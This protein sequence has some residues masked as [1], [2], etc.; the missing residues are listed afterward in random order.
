[1]KNINICKVILRLQ[2]PLCLCMYSNTLKKDAPILHLMNFG[3]D[4]TL[5][6]TFGS[7]I[8]SWQLAARA[9]HAAC[10]SFPSGWRS[11]ND[12][13]ATAAGAASGES[14]CGY[15]LHMWSTNSWGRVKAGNS[16]QQT[17][18]CQL[19]RGSWLSKGRPGRA[20]PTTIC[21]EFYSDTFQA[22]SGASADALQTFHLRW[23]A[24]EKQ[25]MCLRCSVQA[26]PH[27]LCSKCPATTCIHVFILVSL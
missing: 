8:S 17:S 15:N 14:V 16:S 7:Q 11:N 23:Q 21:V 24:K 22:K 3:I 20:Q 10:L 2:F 19:Q 4:A 1:M 18:G 5:M 26:D 25:A 13:T 6:L 27:E 12:I 9:A